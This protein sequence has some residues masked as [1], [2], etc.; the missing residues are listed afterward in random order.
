MTDGT[1]YQ[2]PA[3][4]LARLIRFDTTNPP[5]NEAECVG[6][7]AGL[8]E[9]Y[10][11]AS[12]I[13][14]KA[15]G[16][17]NLVA[18]LKGSGDAPPLL[19]YGHVDVVTTAGQPWTRDPFGGETVD[20]YVWGRGALDMKGGIAML[21]SAF[22]RTKAEGV[23]LPGDVILCILSDEENGG[24]Y[25]A[26]YLV[27]ERPELFAGVRRALGE[28]GG[29]TLHLAGKRFYP[30]MLA[31][32]QVCW[33]K[34][35]V[36]GPAGHGSMP[37]RGGAMAKAG[38]F[39]QALDQGRPPVR[40]TPAVAA[41]I[42]TM[43]G[44]LPEPMRTGLLG[45]LDPAKTDQIAAQLG[46]VGPLLAPLLRNTVSPTVIRGGEKSNVIPSEVTI[47]MDGRLLP[48][49]S[50]EELIAEVREIVGPD[51][52]M[53][54]LRH[55]P[56]PLAE[57]DMALFETLAE[58]LRAADPEGIPIPFVLTG[59]TDGRFFARL[60]IQTYGYLPMPLPPDFDFI[61]T[62]HAADERVPIAALDFGA[63]RLFEALQRFG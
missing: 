21:V 25:G 59:A 23:S 48:G 41:M 51:A 12:A 7:I 6:Y 52:E 8:L 19:L 18:H 62:I 37:I 46:P 28:F 17:P 61:R 29:F 44:A 39:L 31:E 60:G 14:E 58:I 57:P 26:R 2:R 53:E 24:V 55:D 5:G 1:I 16:R 20:G 3:E 27:E 50:P 49:A 22:L 43:A 9:S 4:L 10:G 35:T 33:I 34:A 30:I 11:I 32:K 42:R 36:R 13:Y 45:L 47:E 56:Y 54:V 15:P 40:I 38:A 63:D